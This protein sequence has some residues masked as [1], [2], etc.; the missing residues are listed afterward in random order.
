M[1]IPFETVIL[2]AELIKLIPS[3]VQ[4]AGKQAVMTGKVTR[5]VL[6]M[7]V[8]IGKHVCGHVRDV[9]PVCGMLLFMLL[10]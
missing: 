5:V 8:A 7:H 6:T 1:I 3:T 10:L 2:M 4:P 9:G